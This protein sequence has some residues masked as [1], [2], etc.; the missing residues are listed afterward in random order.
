MSEYRR[1]VGKF[2]N[3]ER[4]SYP[5]MP[6]GQ[7][8]ADVASKFARI[9]DRAIRKRSPDALAAFDAIVSETTLEDCWSREARRIYVNWLTYVSD[10]RNYPASQSQL[11]MAAPESSQV[12]AS[13]ITMTNA[14]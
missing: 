12:V 7:H 13:T 8:S 5:A 11:G 1:D 14:G 10:R 3:G 6:V 2:L 4:S 9:A